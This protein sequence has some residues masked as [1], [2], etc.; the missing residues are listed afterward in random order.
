MQGLGVSVPGMEQQ[1][2]LCWPVG[3]LQQERVMKCSDT[4]WEDSYKKTKTK[5]Q[6]CD[7]RNGGN[8]TPIPF[9]ALCEVHEVNDSLLVSLNP[10]A[11]L[12]HGI[13]TLWSPGGDRL[14]GVNM[15]L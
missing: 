9:Q 3:P 15:V 12:P 1:T 4:E 6:F 11:G 8:A 14:E 2:S 7:I 13:L 5:T 10:T